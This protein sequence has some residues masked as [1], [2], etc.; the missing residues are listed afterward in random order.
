MAVIL[1]Y[2]RSSFRHWYLRHFFREGREKI[3][4]YDVHNLMKYHESNVNH[5]YNQPNY[6]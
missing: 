6:D 3:L 4:R 1:I 2:E 5:T